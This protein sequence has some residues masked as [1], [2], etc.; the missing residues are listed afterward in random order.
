MAEDPSNTVAAAEEATGAV[1]ERWVWELAQVEEPFMPDV[2][3]GM[4]VD[5]YDAFAGGVVVPAVR[6]LS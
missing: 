5:L 4:D 3:N 1:R 6:V 2:L